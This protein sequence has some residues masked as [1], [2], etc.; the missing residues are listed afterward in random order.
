MTD[1]RQ[2]DGDPIDVRL[3]TREDLPHEAFPGGCNEGLRVFFTTEVHQAL[4]RHAVMIPRSRS[5]AFWSEAGIGT[6]PVRSSR[7]WSRSVAR[8]LKLGLPR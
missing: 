7:S 2:N 1:A 8:A 5:A 3:L 6:R 4:W